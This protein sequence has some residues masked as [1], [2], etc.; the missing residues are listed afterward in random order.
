MVAAVLLILKDPALD[1]SALFLAES[2]DCDHLAAVR[3]ERT[4]A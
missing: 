2:R 1:A 4:G 3:S